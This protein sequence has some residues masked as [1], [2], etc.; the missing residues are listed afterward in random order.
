M[1]KILELKNKDRQGIEKTVGKIEI[2]NKAN[3][4]A[5]LYFYGDICSSTWGC[6]EEE[7]KCPQDVSN[8]LKELD[9]TKD[10]NIYINSGGGSV[11][12]GLAIY[13]QLKRHPA[14]KTVYVDG[15]AASIASVIALAGDKVIIPK[16]AQFMIH[17][18]WSVSWG[19]ANDLRKTADSLDSC[20][21]SILNVYEENLRQDI[22]IED[23]K[24]MVNDETWLTGDEAA[25]YFNIEV[26]EE[27]EAVACISNYFENY[28]HTPK[29]FFKNKQ[30]KNANI[31]NKKKLQARL[32]VMKAKM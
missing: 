17:K 1:N 16:N 7:D 18:P 24:Q 10:I 25:K 20:E 32:R 4:K 29:N 21:Q 26:E 5:E 22:D 15:L 6:W 27:N 8:F 13:N 28:K 23:I 3:D 11:F 12:A 19:N 30:Y 31:E 2:K 14:N 9:G